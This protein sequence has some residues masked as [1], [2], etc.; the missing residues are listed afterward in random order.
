MA[1][2]SSPKVGRG[3]CPS[4]GYEVVYQKSSGGMLSHKCLG[5]FSSGYAEPGG[6][7]YR[8]RM[9]AM[10]ERFDSEELPKA[11]PTEPAPRI[12]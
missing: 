10:T 6:N 9:A 3:P 12:A 2:A 1:R 8:G 11:T 7:A 4:C 5:C